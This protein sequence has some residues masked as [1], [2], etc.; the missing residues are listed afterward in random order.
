M[1]YRVFTIPS[2]MGETF[3]SLI[4]ALKYALEAIDKSPLLEFKK[5]IEAED[6]I[7]DDP[8]QWSEYSFKIE[9]AGTGE[10]I[11]EEPAK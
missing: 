6:D 9:N 2:D 11:W 5:T 10:I 8:Y 1:I 7:D 4:L 3:E